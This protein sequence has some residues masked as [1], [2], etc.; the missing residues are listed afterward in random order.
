MVTNTE[1]YKEKIGEKYPD[2]SIQCIRKEH[3][4]VFIDKKDE[5]E[6]FSDEDHCSFAY[7]STE[8]TALANAYLR[9]L[10]EAV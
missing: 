5:S 3:Y 7:G 4:V 2:F 8:E 10:R 6:Y 9:V 1:I